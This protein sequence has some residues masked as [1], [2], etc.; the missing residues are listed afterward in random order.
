[1][2]GNWV[3]R[4]E[5]PDPFQINAY[6]I[7]TA[8]REPGRFHPVPLTE[9]WLVKFGFERTD[10]SIEESGS[11]APLSYYSLR[12][13]EESSVDLALLSNTLDKKMRVGLFPYNESGFV[14]DYVHQLQQLIK[15]LTGS[16]PTEESNK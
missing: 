11:D 6:G 10:V 16:T 1:M 5:V 3:T 12:L 4:P 14:Y 13:S 7:M 15:A 8:S 9:E 2:V